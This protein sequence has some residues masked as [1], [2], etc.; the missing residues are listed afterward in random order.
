[1]VKS[2]ILILS[3]FNNIFNKYNI[4]QGGDFVEIIVIILKIIEG[5]FYNALGSGYPNIVI[6]IFNFDC[7]LVISYSLIID[8]IIFYYL[9][10]RVFTKSKMLVLLII[11]IIFTVLLGYLALFSIIRN[12]QFNLIITR[13]IGLS[14]SIL[15]ISFSYYRYRTF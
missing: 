12:Y 1:M 7:L 6:N 9:K 11:L 15:L 14:F 5:F 13:F 10:N 4:F 8:I 3:N 2:N